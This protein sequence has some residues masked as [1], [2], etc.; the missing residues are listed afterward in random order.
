VYLDVSCRSVEGL[1]L[2]DLCDVLKEWN[3]VQ[4]NSAP[5]KHIKKRIEKKK[6]K[7]IG[8]ATKIFQRDL[9]APGFCKRIW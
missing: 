7:E 3:L 4:D 1:Q 5:C 2:I 8:S 6:D 9:A